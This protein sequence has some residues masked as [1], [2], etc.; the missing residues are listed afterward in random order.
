MLGNLDSYS[1]GLLMGRIS[2]VLYILTL[3]SGICRRFTLKGRIVSVL[4]LYRKELGI[5][6]YIFAFMHALF[7][8]SFSLEIP[9]FRIFGIL[10]LLILTPLFLTANKFATLRLK[11]NWKKL[12]KLTY[13]ALGLIFLHTALIRLSIF[14][15]LAFTTLILLAS[16]FV[17]DKFARDKIKQL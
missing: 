2:L 13:P 7:F 4:T 3:I 12:H 9:V 11:Q 15:A 10:G 17:Y 16:S 8:V 5:A 14:S 6:M 1:A